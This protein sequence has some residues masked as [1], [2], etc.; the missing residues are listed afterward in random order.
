MSVWETIGDYN[1]WMFIDYVDYDIIVFMLIV[2]EVFKILFT[3]SYYE[4]L[5]VIPQ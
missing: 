5:A 1:E 2:P 3:E 4:A